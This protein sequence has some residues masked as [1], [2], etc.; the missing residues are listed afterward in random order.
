MKNIYKTFLGIAAWIL[1]LSCSNDD[2]AATGAA[3]LEVIG[4]WDLAQVNVSSAQDIDMDGTSSTNLM[5]ELDCISG[6]LLIDGDMVWTF[7]QTG[8]NITA[9]TNGQFVAQC[10]GSVAATGAWSSSGTEVV[11][12]GSS[13]LG[14]LTID[15]DQLTKDIGDDL[16]GIRSYV[17]VRRPQ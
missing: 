7:E 4:I 15:G 8:I 16:P 9:I 3:N 2:G 6:T 1:V 13:L 17:Y 11:L 10:S 14:T 5:N 12:Q